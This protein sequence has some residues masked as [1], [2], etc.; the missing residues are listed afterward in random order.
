MP[1]ELL[2]EAK[3]ASWLRPSEALELLPADWDMSRKRRTILRRLAD[4]DIKAFAL[5][6]KYWDQRG[7]RP[8]R[9][10]SIGQHLWSPPWQ[11]YDRDFWVVG[12]VA[13]DNEKPP[14]AF[15]VVRLDELNDEPE[16]ATMGAS[17][18]GVRFDPVSFRQAFDLPASSPPA[19]QE[20]DANPPTA[21]PPA[22]P[23]KR[24]TGK[25][26]RPAGKHGQPMARVTR[27]LLKMSPGD[28]ASCTVDSVAAELTAEYQ[29]LG[30]PPPHPDNA[31]KDAAGI[32]RVVREEEV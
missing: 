8:A 24:V 2:S 15:Y 11:L 31:W 32:L 9:L 19:D 23:T 7:S 18:T 16:D 26:G 20:V 10:V 30:L 6:A 25:G 12:D 29:E 4:G 22:K 3:I 28:L 21:P 14:Q 13:F 17:F 5:K 27:R 1:G